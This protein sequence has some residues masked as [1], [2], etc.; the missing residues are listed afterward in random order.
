M[1][2]R[3]AYTLLLL[4]ALGIN[5]SYSQDFKINLN[6]LVD[7]TQISS[8][9]ME[10]MRL[11]WWIPLEFWDASF[12]DDPS[13]SDAEINE[14]KDV[15]GDYVM[16]AVLEG[17]IGLFG[18]VTYKSRSIIETGLNI[19]DEIGMQYKA[20][21]EENISADA[22]NLISIF[23]PVFS[24]MMGEL[25]ENMQIFLFEA[26]DADGRLR[27]DPTQP[28]SLKINIFEESFEWKLPLGALLPPKVCPVDGES[29]SG[30]WNFCPWHGNELKSE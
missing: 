14:F 18:G 13:I 23:Q 8:E 2:K 15:L 9:D 17:K 29:L 27:F 7:E 16:I 1:S 6:D 10:L 19:E 20:L 26:Y 28:G 24:N 25:G 21:A 4:L 3:F 22:R 11:A 12:A 30:A 5:N